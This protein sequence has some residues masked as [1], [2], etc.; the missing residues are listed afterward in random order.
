MYIEHSI[1]EPGNGLKLKI[2]KVPS[3]QLSRQRQG[4]YQLKAHTGLSQHPLCMSEAMR[5]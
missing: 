4:Q 2:S 3:Y 5:V 1:T